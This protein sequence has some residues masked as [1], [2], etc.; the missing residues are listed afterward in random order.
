MAL[1][2]MMATVRQVAL[3][4]APALSVLIEASCFLMRFLI[5]PDLRL[6]TLFSLIRSLLFLTHAILVRSD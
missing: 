5:V 4:A 2:A 1:D 3:S 6:L